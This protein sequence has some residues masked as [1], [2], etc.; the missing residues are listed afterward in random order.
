[1][2]K[3]ISKEIQSKI[4]EEVKKGESRYKIAIE[5]GIDPHAVYKYTK[6]LPKRK[7][8]HLSP[9]KKAWIKRKAKEG[10]SKYQISKE[11]GIS[12]PTVCKI[13]KDF[14]NSKPGWH[15]IRG[16]TLELLQ[17]ILEKGY[18]RSK[19]GAKAYRTL[20][21]YFPSIQRAEVNGEA[22]YFWKG[23]DRDAL[24]AFL[25]KL[26]TKVI[27]YGKLGQ[28]TRTFGMELSK[29]EKEKFFGRSKKQKRVKLQQRENDLL[30]K[31]D[32]SLVELFMRNY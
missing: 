17:D 11:L 2:P 15:G 10:K 24:K 27:N 3:G 32:G 13:A 26:H 25:G 23:K 28:I 4:R 9:A 19:K 29:G 21:K 31:N 6:D 18:G 5:F 22:I 12:P 16:K 8:K 14:P 7:V 20:K 30:L 1:M